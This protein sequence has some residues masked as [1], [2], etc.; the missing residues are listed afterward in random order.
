M[1]VSSFFLPYPVPY[2]P[3][4][5]AKGTKL[6]KPSSSKQPNI[7]EKKAF[8][9]GSARLPFFVLWRRLI[10][11]R[12]LK[13]KVLH[14]IE[15]RGKGTIFRKSEDSSSSNELILLFSEEKKSSVK[16][17]ERVDLSSQKRQT[18]RI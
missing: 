12:F 18:W 9:R 1:S 14:F 10:L 15:R 8:S 3:K 16:W 13:E 11:Q 5:A 7:Q 6:T 2:P 4:E 17:R